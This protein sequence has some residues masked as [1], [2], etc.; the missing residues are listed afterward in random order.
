M[1]AGI[2]KIELS[3]HL[4]LYYQCKKN[5]YTKLSTVDERRQ[6]GFK[7][8]FRH[9][10]LEDRSLAFEETTGI[11]WLLY[12]ENEGLFCLLCRKHNVDNPSNKSKIFNAAPSVQFR[13][14]AI[15]EH[16]KGKQ[17]QSAVQ[18]EMAQRV[19]VFHR[20][21]EERELVK[22]EVLHN[23]FVALY[24]LAKESVANKKFFSL[25][26]LFC[27]TGLKKMEFFPYKSQS[28]IREMA[29][30]IGSVLKESV[31]CQVRKAQSYG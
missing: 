8:K 7:R 6:K 4:H 19:S 17:H 31:L 21:E 18:A 25:L 15:I 27:V 22:D 23:A 20:Q 11:W 30:T 9:V 13:K 28:T 29:L 10:W 16:S 14:E 1:L 3:G 24:W 12:F 5:D 26:N 2:A